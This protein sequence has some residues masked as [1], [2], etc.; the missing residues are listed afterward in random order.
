MFKSVAVIISCILII[1]AVG[2]KTESNVQKGRPPDQDDSDDD[3]DSSDIPD[4]PTELKASADPD[5]ILLSWRDNS[6]NEQGFRIYFSDATIEDA[7]YT[8]LVDV[9]TDTTQYYHYVGAEQS[10][11]YYVTAF[12][13]HGESEKS[14]T[15]SDKTRPNE[16]AISY[17][18]CRCGLA[19]GCRIIVGWM[20]SKVD[21][22]YKLKIDGKEHCSCTESCLPCDCS[23]GT[24]FGCWVTAET[25]LPSTSHQIEVYVYNDVGEATSYSSVQC[26]AP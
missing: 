25:F 20:D 6:D 17:A 1:F 3:S 18:E 11:E 12:N 9:G 5:A 24:F 14:N 23:G 10:F 13:S 2:C 15:A 21:D 26:P 19:K 7:P 22:G 8:A 16:P 4:K